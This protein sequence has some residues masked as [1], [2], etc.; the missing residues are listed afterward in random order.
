MRERW[1]E[2]D[3]YCNWPSMSKVCIVMRNLRKGGMNE[4]EKG[5]DQ[6]RDERRRQLRIGG[7]QVLEPGKFGNWGW[8]C[9]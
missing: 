5:Y 1:K 3:K 7:D 6:S 9:Y 8:N 4:R 2:C